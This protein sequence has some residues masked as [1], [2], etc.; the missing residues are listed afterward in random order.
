MTSKGVFITASAVAAVA[1]VGA[2]YTL[3][4][5]P[6]GP[7]ISA[8][9][10]LVARGFGHGATH[11]RRPEFAAQCP[12]RARARGDHGTGQ[13]GRQQVAAMLTAGSGQL[14]PDGTA[15]TLDVPAVANI[16]GSVAAAL[17]PISSGM[18]DLGGSDGQLAQSVNGNVVRISPLLS[19]TGPNATVSA[20][21]P[22]DLAAA[23]APQLDGTNGAGAVTLDPQSG[24]ITIDLSKLLGSE[25]TGD[26]TVPTLSPTDIAEIE[27]DI[28][29]ASAS[30]GDNVV[31]TATNSVEN[32]PVNVD[33]NVK[34]LTTPTVSGDGS[35]CT[36]T[37]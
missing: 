27:A 30:M 4:A 13:H 24:T 20:T 34:L 14:S 31:N 3:A 28:N 5:P 2:A 36:S 15:L 29:A 26:Q 17:A 8:S 7:A 6:P 35:S 22:I 1:I 21:A 33:A 18:G 37:G 9:I 23:V 32:T 10:R 11:R 12:F 25:T 19:L 16:D